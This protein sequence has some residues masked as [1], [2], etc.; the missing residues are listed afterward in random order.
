MNRTIY[1]VEPRN[2]AIAYAKLAQSL[3]LANI[4]KWITLNFIKKVQNSAKPRNNEQFLSY[5]SVRYYEALLFI[6]HAKL[7]TNRL[8][9][10]T[11]F[12]ETSQMWERYSAHM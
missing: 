8:G 2:S 6:V 4:F 11:Y 7:Q 9:S 1:T 12:N 10:R 5:Q 3:I